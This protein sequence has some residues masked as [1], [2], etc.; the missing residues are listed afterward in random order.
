MEPVHTRQW[1]ECKYAGGGNEPDDENDEE[2]K[3]EG[4]GQLEEL[5]KAKQSEVG[6]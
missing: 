3:D 1:D 6:L 4:W 2:W 5:Q